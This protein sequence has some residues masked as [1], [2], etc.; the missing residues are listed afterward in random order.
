[1]SA[2]E[3]EEWD[4]T[5]A[6]RKYTELDDEEGG[7]KGGNGAFN[8]DSTP[9]MPSAACNHDHSNERAIYDLP[10]DEKINRMNQFHARGNAFFEEG[11][12]DR[13]YLQYRHAMVYY[14]YT[15]PVSVL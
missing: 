5:A 15:F 13:A 2:F 11:Q 3:S 9:A 7:K 12:Y 4:W 8:D 10:L 1:M 6:Y 14:D